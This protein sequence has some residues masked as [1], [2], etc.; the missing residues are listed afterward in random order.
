MS[1][2]E[3]CFKFLGI[4]ATILTIITSLIL[5]Y[6]FA[7]GH[8]TLLINFGGS[9]S[10]PTTITGTTVIQQPAASITVTPKETASTTVTPPKETLA[11][12]S[13][14]PV[15]PKQTTS[16]T[17]SEKFL[18]LIDQTP[19]FANIGI[20][21]IWVA[22]GLLCGFILSIADDFDGCNIG[23][24]S[25]FGCILVGGLFLLVFHSFMVS[26]IATGVL[27]LIIIVFVIVFGWVVN[28][29]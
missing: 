8:Q 12:I 25:I 15:Q 16:Q 28:N 10:S 17:H 18:W 26:I 14:A 13:N 23:F 2:A 24:W 6:Q 20:W 27:G 5:I 9:S 4:V 1:D 29:F 11:A 7:T 19:S 22:V 21:I 3:G